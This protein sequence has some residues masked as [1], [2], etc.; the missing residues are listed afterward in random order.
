MSAETP[1]NPRAVARAVA[2]R[3]RWPW[4]R[5]YARAKL[6]W[7]PA[8]AAVAG[9]LSESDVAVLDIGCGLGLLGFYLRERGY[10]GAYLGVDFDAPKIAEAQRIARI[11][12]MDLVFVDGDARALPEFSGHVVLLDLLHYLQSTDQ[13][14]LLREAAA[15]VAESGVLIARNVLRASGWRFHVTVLQE[16]FIHAVRWMRSPPLHYP[17]RDEIEAPL[18]ASGLDVDVRPL[19]GNTPFNSFLI[20]AR[21]GSRTPQEGGGLHPDAPRGTSRTI[22][23][24]AAATCRT[25]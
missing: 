10:K 6:S 13:Q 3:F 24:E 22:A 1:A 25:P 11:A 15:R 21:R 16:R 5:D 20:V 12:G 7:D 2:A 18:R 23:D 14:M 17:L 19:W 8:Y 9:V 4:Q